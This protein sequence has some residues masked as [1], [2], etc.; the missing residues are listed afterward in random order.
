MEPQDDPG[1]GERYE[2]IPWEQL[3]TGPSD[4][5]RR[6]LVIG[7]SA[8]ALVAVVAFLAGSR[9]PPA[10]P[11]VAATAT[12]PP[13]PP[14]TVVPE[15]APTTVTEAAPP[16][17]ADLR[18][19]APPTDLVSLVAD[20]VAGLW[21]LEADAVGV[22]SVGDGLFLAT[23]ALP[24]GEGLATDYAMEV[25]ARLEAGAL[26]VDHL[27]PVPVVDAATEVPDPVADAVA[28]AVAAWDGATVTD[29]GRDADG[30]W[31]EVAIGEVGRSV[32]IRPSVPTGLGS[33]G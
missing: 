31:A 10:P 24:T 13:P 17:E 23:V 11:A 18:A 32:L 8:L 2:Q 16:S 27:H 20:H 19:A 26:V 7:G 14:P 5:R 3:V 29:I 12:V 6:W 33:G 4:D 22:R 1:P 15:S 25:G 9:P 21:G 30:W 28:D